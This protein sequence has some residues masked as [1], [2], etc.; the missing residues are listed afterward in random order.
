MELWIYLYS[1]RTL[2]NNGNLLSKS[3][4]RQVPYPSSVTL[5]CDTFSQGR[6]RVINTFVFIFDSVWYSRHTVGNEGL[7]RWRRCRVCDR[8]GAV[9]GWGTTS[10]PTELGLRWCLYQSSSSGISGGA[11]SNVLFLIVTPSNLRRIDILPLKTLR[12]FGQRNFA[13]KFLFLTLKCVS[14]STLIPQSSQIK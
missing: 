9:S 1:F 5:M 10:F 6:R 14:C 4:F 11:F 12:H 8:G 2:N 7:L 3:R 13:T